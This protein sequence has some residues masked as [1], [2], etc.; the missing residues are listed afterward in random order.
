MPP[1]DEALNNLLW[2]TAP[3]RGVLKGEARAAFIDAWAQGSKALCRGVFTAGEEELKSPRKA[4]EELF[5]HTLDACA[6]LGVKPHDL[7]PMF[8]DRA[9]GGFTTPKQ[10]LDAL[11]LLG[12][13]AARTARLTLEAKKEDA[14]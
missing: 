4:A 3:L 11:T 5:R 1:L 2:A 12:R 9:D 13:S 14:A 8:N 10:P 6:A 7:V